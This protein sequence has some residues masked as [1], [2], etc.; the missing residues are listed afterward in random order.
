MARRAK[1][2]FTGRHMATVLVVGF[3]IVVAVN[4][5]MAS[6]AA[7]GFH[8]VVVENS[9]VASQKYNDWLAKAEAAK[10]LG[11][12]ASLARDDDGY[13]VL[14]TKGV[15]SDAELTAQLRRPIG[16]HDFASLTFEPV[17]KGKYRSTKPVADGRWTTRLFIESAGQKW[18][19]ESEL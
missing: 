17:G 11:W 15:P 19:E 9:Y 12:E 6:Y 4:F 18:A 1:K 16:E 10:A 5:T 8:G 2:T 3:G 7:G 13:V 14:N